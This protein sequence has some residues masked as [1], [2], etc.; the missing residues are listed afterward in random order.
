M[1]AEAARIGTH[2]GARLRTQNG[3]MLGSRGEAVG[4]TK[5]A[6]S[7]PIAG[8][9]QRYQVDV[10]SARQS[11]RAD[12]AHPNRRSPVSRLEPTRRYAALNPKLVEAGQPLGGEGHRLSLA[13]VAA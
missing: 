4:A 10:Q 12:A 6:A 9:M 5:A 1:G 7:V 2:A 8:R 11:P 3:E 13:H